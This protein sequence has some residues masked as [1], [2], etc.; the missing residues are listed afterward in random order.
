M[1]KELASRT[2]RIALTS[3]VVYFVLQVLDVY[4]TYLVTPDLHREENIIVTSFD[5]GWSYIIISAIAASLVMIA[6][7]LWAWKTIVD[8]A[9]RSNQTYKEFY[10]HILFDQRPSSGPHSKHDLKGVL[11]SIALIILFS[12]IAAKLFVVIWNGLIFLFAI[13]VSDFTQMILIKNFVAGL[14]GLFMFFYFPS[15]LHKKTSE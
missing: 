13:R 12:L 9:P 15:L 2:Y 7:Q 10:H 6:G 4:I 14:F 8:R 11:V 1:N 3:S 5:L